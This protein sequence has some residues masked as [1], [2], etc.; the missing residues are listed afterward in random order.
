MAQA[1]S[2]AHDA[3]IVHRDLKPANVILTRTGVKLLD[4][5]LAKLRYD[6]PSDLISA[7]STDPPL[8]GPGT[9]PGTLQYMAPEQL[10]GQDADAQSDIFAFGTVLYE[11]ISGRK[12]FEARSQASLIAKILEADPP[13]LSTIVAP[14]PPALEHLVQT[15]LAKSADTRW[16]SIHDVLLE[17]RRIERTD[18][19]VQ[20]PCRSSVGCRRGAPG[21]SSLGPSSR[22]SSRGCSC[23]G[24]RNPRAPRCALV[25]TS[26]CQSASA[27]TGRTGRSCRPTAS[28]SRSRR[29]RRASV[30]CGC[31]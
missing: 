11:M 20:G 13:P 23:C 18:R 10:E 26:R 4:F 27:S 21:T 28:V 15:C 2:A 3:D 14:P 9:M 30:N 5:G 6:V 19:P 1:L 22:C 16:K 29:V 17:L 24:R 7:A 8:T 25:S 12:A 31:G